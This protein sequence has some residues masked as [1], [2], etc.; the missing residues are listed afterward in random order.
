MRFLLNY[1][2]TMNC[3]WLLF[4]HNLK[5]LLDDWVCLYIDGLWIIGVDCEVWLELWSWEFLVKNE[6]DDGNLMIWCYELMVWFILMFLL[7]MLTVSEVCTMIFGSIGIKIEF[8]EWVPNREP[9]SEFPYSWQSCWASRCLGSFPD[10][11]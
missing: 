7:Y 11:P 10:T 2:K 6:Y 5:H 1:V 3:W 4:K 9:I 8:L